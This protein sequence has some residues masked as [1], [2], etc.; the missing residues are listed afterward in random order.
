MQPCGLEVLEK[1]GED[2]TTAEL[3]AR[4]EEIGEP[5]LQSCIFKVGDD[6]RQ[7]MLALQVISLFDQIFKAIDLEL[8]LFPYR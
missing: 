7:D 1:C 3:E 8:F 6:V 4:K 2:G 5:R